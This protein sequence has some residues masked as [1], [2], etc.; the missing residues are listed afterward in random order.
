MATS[1][2]RWGV[3]FDG[4]MKEVQRTQE[5]PF[6]EAQWGHR[7]RMLEPTERGVARGP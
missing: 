6:R 1:T 7:R 4:R 2:S 3:M 5:S